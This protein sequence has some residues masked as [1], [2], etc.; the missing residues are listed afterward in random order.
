MYLNWKNYYVPGVENHSEALKQIYGRSFIQ[1]LR[2]EQGKLITVIT[3]REV[4]TGRMIRS[5][6]DYM[7]F[8]FN[9]RTYYIPYQSI[10]YYYSA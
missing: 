9:D 4:L 6:M 1:Q 7:E 3:G 5:T 8:Q 10:L 2:Q